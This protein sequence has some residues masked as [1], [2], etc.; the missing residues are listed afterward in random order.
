MIL[1]VYVSHHTIMLAQPHEESM[2]DV[3][4]C[5]MNANKWNYNAYAY[6]DRPVYSNLVPFN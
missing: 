4:A 6:D 3:Y 1:A 2:S 5:T